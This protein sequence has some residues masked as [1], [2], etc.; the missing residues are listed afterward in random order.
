MRSS[1]TSRA[2]VLRTIILLAVF[3][4]TVSLCAA[5]GVREAASRSPTVTVV[6]SALTSE[7]RAERLPLR[8]C[9]RLRNEDELRARVIRGEVV[10]LQELRA[11]YFPTRETWSQVSRWASARGYTVETESVT[12]LTVYAHAPVSRIERDFSMKFSRLV[13]ADGAERTS[14]IEP[15]VIPDEIALSVSHVSGLNP[16]LRPRAGQSVTVTLIAEGG[17]VHLSPKT[18]AQVYGAADVG[19]DGTG[20]T[21]VVLG[22][23]RI[24]GADLTAFWTRCGLPTTL[25]QFTEI[26]PYPD[27]LARDAS[28]ETKDVEWASAMAPNAKILYISTIGPERVTDILLERLE[29][30]STIHQMTVSYG[31]CEASYE[32]AHSTPGDSQSYLTLAAAGIT[33]FAASGDA[34]SNADFVNGVLGKN[35]YYQPGGALAPNYPASDPYV[36]G[37]GGTAVGFTTTSGTDYT[38][39]YREGAWCLPDP[40]LSAHAG[41]PPNY[42]FAASTGGV[43]LFFQRMSWQ[44][45]HPLLSGPM[46]TVPDIAAIAAGSPI[47]YACYGGGAETTFGGTSL[48][49]P[50]W[51]GL[52][53]LINEAREKAG[54]APVGLLG[55]RIYQ[56]IGTGA[57]NAMTVGSQNGAVFT[58]TSTNGAYG[59]GKDYNL[60][61]GLGSPNFPALLA[62]LSRVTAPMI[63][64]P[65]TAQTIEAGGVVTFT[66]TVVGDPTPMLMWSFGDDVL[67]DGVLGD[68]T[69]VSGATTDKLTLQGVPRSANGRTISLT[70]TNSGGKVTSAAVVLT[71]TRPTVTTG[72][73]TYGVPVTL[74]APQGVPDTWYQWTVDGRTIVNALSAS[75]STSFPGVY[76]VAELTSSGVKEFRVGDLKAAVRQVNLSTRALVRTGAEIEFAG[77]V[78]DGPAG[79]MKDVL[80]RAVGPTLR[81]FGITGVLARPVITLFT[82]DG[83][84]V[85]TNTGWE[86]PLVRS[87][88]PVGF[89]QVREATAAD[90]DHL[91]TFPLPPGSADSALVAT[92]PPGAYTMHV[93]GQGDSSGIALAEVYEMNASSSPL[94]VNVSTRAYV[95]PGEALTVMGVVS[96][97]T[98][99]IKCLI[100]A[101]GPTL[102]TFNVE[103]PLADPTLT[104]LDANGQTI[105]TNQ[106][107][108][109]PPQRSAV[110]PAA[111][112]RGTTADEMTQTG[113]FSFPEQSADSAMV[114]VLPPGLYTIQVTGTSGGIALAEAYQMK[115]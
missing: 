62:A 6:R 41:E 64:L 8:F 54:L 38:L 47:P 61:S 56:L 89:V 75:Y 37:V 81:G 111:S 71:V 48:S 99:P 16:H 1:S 76:S 108:Q 30:D 31:L 74:I 5:T 100:R 40:P 35:A 82:P 114:A 11:R 109:N 87:G 107:W 112:V 55:P 68:G 12:H 3:V 69:V 83:T 98:Q 17:F 45:G 50:V 21:L 65:P 14:S 92:V 88:R 19:L 94:L 84:P 67:S 104:L 78:V 46:R 95:G 51:A 86:N 49:S 15:V 72:N 110:L 63:A 36:T 96:S 26:D 103:A 60:V 90:M 52:C 53:A 70:A 39:P 10:S 43:S 85:A 91:G 33:T 58:S 24:N 29:T 102:R 73:V 42:D 27:Y 23:G 66:A 25:A 113:G 80:L 93:S 97:G 13:E 44:T 22:G 20:Q 105:A 4:G 101:V 34:G 57:F 32:Q 59:V 106:G 77:F 2:A 28:E 18:V 115:P 9:L 7:E 79:S